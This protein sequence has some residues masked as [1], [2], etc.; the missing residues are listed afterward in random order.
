MFRT[1]VHLALSR[2][3]GVAVFFYLATLAIVPAVYGYA[4]G[5]LLLVALGVWRTADIRRAMDSRDCLFASGFLIYGVLYVILIAWHQDNVSSF[6]RPSRFVAAAIILTMLLRVCVPV[7]AVFTGAAIGALLSGMFAAYEVFVS[8]VTRV[9]SFDNAIYFGN[10]ALI[11]ALV[12]FVGLLAEL[13]RCARQRGLVLLYGCGAIGGV[14]AL[15]LS[16]TRG[17]WLALPVIA[18]VGFWTYRQV[19]ARRPRLLAATLVV[20]AALG[21]VAN[22]MQI[23]SDRVDAAMS[24]AQSYFSEH[25][26][27]TSVGLRFE[28]WKAGALM[29]SAH[30]VV[31]VGEREFH[32]ELQALVESG[33]VDNGLLTFRHLHNQFVD[34]AAKGGVLAV[35]AL[36]MVFG[37]PTVLFWRYLSSGDPMIKSCAFG[38]VAFTLSFVVFCLT[39]GMFSR[40]LGVMMY[41]ILPLFLWA[42][43]RQAE[44]GASDR[45][46]SELAT[47][48]RLD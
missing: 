22:N 31:G 4:P 8:G 45:Q 39:Q 32:G 26:V 27:Q 23:V 1:S 17:G 5:L 25:R 28:M 44:R 30:P 16:G 15:L 43:I 18:L 12:S 41:V 9:S 3:I 36:L 34:H 21:I 42:I 35:V 38:G 47:A 20:V 48:R 29:F 11:L 13:P 7:K 2:F 10:G 19:L 14:A 24:Q 46:A 40:N 6:D 37:V 33:Q